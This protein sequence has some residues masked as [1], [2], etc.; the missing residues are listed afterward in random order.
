MFGVS[1]LRIEI[2]SVHNV[3]F[4]CFLPNNYK[5]RSFV[6]NVKATGRIEN[7]KTTEIMTEIYIYLEPTS[8]FFVG[9]SAAPRNARYNLLVLRMLPNPIIFSHKLMRHIQNIYMT[10]GYTTKW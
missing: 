3:S 2:L 1:S 7:F 10:Y 8:A 4:I 5:I 9:S 6:S